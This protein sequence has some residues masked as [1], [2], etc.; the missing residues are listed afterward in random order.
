MMRRLF[1]PLL[2]LAAL[3]PAAA[4]ARCAPI[5]VAQDARQSD[6]VVEAVLEHAGQHAHFRTTVVWKGGAQAPAE[7]ELGARRGRGRWDWSES[8]AEGETFLLFLRRT[9]GGDWMV[10][11]CG[12]TGE[13]SDARRMALRA[14]GLAPTSR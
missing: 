8:S 10:M 11:R 2:C 5:S 3:V 13:A 12:A 7:V 6:Y 9:Q 4:S 14:R 1:V